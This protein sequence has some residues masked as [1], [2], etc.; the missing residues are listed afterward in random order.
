ME[1]YSAV[2]EGNLTFCDSA[3]APGEHYAQCN[4]LVR[5]RQVPYDFTLM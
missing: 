5:E 3:D 4:K 1:Y 2:K